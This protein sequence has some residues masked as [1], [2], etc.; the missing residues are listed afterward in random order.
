[1]ST[2]E[3][4]AQLDSFKWISFKAVQWFVLRL[5]LLLHSMRR[6]GGRLP[7]LISEEAASCVEFK[8][9]LSLP[10]M[11]VRFCWI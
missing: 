6:G 9:V 1:M 7:R 3:F 10:F 5:V 11:H 8:A 4:I 2:F